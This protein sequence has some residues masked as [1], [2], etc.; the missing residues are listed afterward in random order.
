[1][2]NKIKLLIVLVSGLYLTGCVSVLSLEESAPQVNVDKDVSSLSL[3]VVD[4]RPYV[5]NNEKKPAFEGVIRSSIG[6]PYSYYTLGQKP[7]AD[8]LAVRLEHGIK[9]QNVNVNVYPTD[10]DTNIEELKST[11]KKDGMPSILVTL[12]EWK[13]DHHAFYDNSWYDVDITVMNN[14]G[15]SVVTKNYKGEN[16]ISGMNISN[17]ML[18]IYKLRFEEILSDK[19][20]LDV[21]KNNS[22]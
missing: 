2:F 11:L 20:L 18:R 1:M 17:E 19:D 12:N 21:L 5:V 15:D 13:Y 22:N 14:S 10:L 16:D 3:S 6:I 9:S 4:L 7:M 8:Y